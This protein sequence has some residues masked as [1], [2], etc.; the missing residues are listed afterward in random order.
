MAVAQVHQRQGQQARFMLALVLLLTVQQH[1]V[2]I[3][4]AFTKAR[5]KVLG[6]FVSLQ[7]SV[8]DQ[9]F[10]CSSGSGSD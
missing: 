2:L 6:R 4:F 9:P 1:Q 3:D 7:T 5:H 10:R 8:I